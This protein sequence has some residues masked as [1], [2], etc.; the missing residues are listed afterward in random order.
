MNDEKVKIPIVFPKSVIDAIKGVELSKLTWRVDALI[1]QIHKLKDPNDYK[2]TLL[3]IMN[4]LG[5]RDVALIISQWLAVEIQLVGH[6]IAEE[7]GE[8][9]TEPW[10][11]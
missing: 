11:M 2:E 10:V 6:R 8:K 5:P 9:R 7:A 4:D 1:E 3:E